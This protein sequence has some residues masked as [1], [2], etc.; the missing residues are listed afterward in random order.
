MKLNPNSFH[1][2]AAVATGCTGA[3]S[4]LSFAESQGFEYLEVL[5]WCSS[6]GDW[7]FI[8][9]RDGWEWYILFQTNN[10]PRPGFSHSIDE[11]NVFFGTT[12]EVLSEIE[13]IFS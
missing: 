5:N 13:L 9:S 10:Y 4:Y 3:G 12:E 11:A 7:E 2:A 1:S 6:A 8:V